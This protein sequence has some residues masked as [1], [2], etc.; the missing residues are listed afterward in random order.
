MNKTRTLISHIEVTSKVNFYTLTEIANALEVEVAH[1]TT[2]Y[3]D[4][5]MVNEDGSA[6]SVLTDKIEKIERENELLNEIIENQKEIIAQ[7]KDK[8]KD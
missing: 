1:F 2:D 7:L 3:T 5:N 6:Y 8:L 4:E